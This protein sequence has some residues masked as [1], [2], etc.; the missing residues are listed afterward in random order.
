M[1]F[2]TLIERVVERCNDIRSRNYQK[3][4][5]MT[6]RTINSYCL[7]NPPVIPRIGETIYFDKNQSYDVVDVIY[8]KRKCHE[9]WHDEVFIEVKPHVSE[10]T[11]SCG[12]YSFKEDWPTI[13][14][15][16]EEPCIDQE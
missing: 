12:S 2:V 6:R 8:S 16:E 14:E 13:L 1:I 10:H 7:C 15:L 4:T 11:Y 9:I 5:R 3:V